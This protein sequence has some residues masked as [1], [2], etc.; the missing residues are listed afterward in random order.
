MHVCVLPPLCCHRCGLSP[1]S[2]VE[3]KK[4]TLA[5]LQDCMDLEDLQVCSKARKCIASLWSTTV[6]RTTD[7]VHGCVIRPA[8]PLWM[9]VLPLRAACNAG[10]AEH[11]PLLDHDTE[12]CTASL[13]DCT[14]RHVLP[15][16]AA[17]TA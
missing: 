15:D 9:T 7:W 13:H 6:L 5:A 16:N 4:S 2:L 10:H 12:G 3:M 17:C 8:L 11:T 14:A 1:N